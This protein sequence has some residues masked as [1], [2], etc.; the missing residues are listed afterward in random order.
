MNTNFHLFYWRSNN[1][2]TRTGKRIQWFK[3]HLTRLFSHVD[4]NVLFCIASW[5]LCI[6][7]ILGVQFLLCTA[8][9]NFFNIFFSFFK[10]EKGK[11]KERKKKTVGD[12][13]D[14]TPQKCKLTFWASMRC[15]IGRVDHLA[16][17]GAAKLKIDRLLQPCKRKRCATRVRQSLWERRLKLCQLVLV[18]IMLQ[19][20]YSGVFS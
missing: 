7:L 19:S 2:A 3:A 17:D 10:E 13:T 6:R 16:N 14:D 20:L 8:Q 15:A 18:N 9:N 5:S 11:K 12:N 1:G 4:S